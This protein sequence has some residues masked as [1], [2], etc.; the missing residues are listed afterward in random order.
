MCL[1]E[2]QCGS[3]LSFLKTKATDNLDGTFTLTGTKIYISAGDHD[4]AEN[5]VHIVLARLPDAPLGTKGI[6]FFGAES[7]SII[8]R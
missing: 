2:P 4:M 1:T 3:D 5:I 8:N 7:S 6:S